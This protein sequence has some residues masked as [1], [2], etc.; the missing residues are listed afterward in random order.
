MLAGP[1][2]SPLTDKPLP[3]LLAGPKSPKLLTKT[4]EFDRKNDWKRRDERDD[5]EFFKE[6]RFVTHIDDGAIEGVKKWYRKLIEEQI[7]VKKK[8]N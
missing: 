4:E 6:P 2:Q 1:S 7:D 5:G 8:E 3:N